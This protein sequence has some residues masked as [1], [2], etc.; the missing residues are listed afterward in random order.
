MQRTI[1]TTARL[2]SEAAQLL[3]SIARVECEGNRSQCLRRIIRE[4]A[5]TRGLREKGESYEH[6]QDDARTVRQHDRA[7]GWRRGP[8]KQS[9]H[10]G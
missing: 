7:S 2:D 9:F 8:F 5:V 1:Y 3:E 6:Q 4:A 10:Q